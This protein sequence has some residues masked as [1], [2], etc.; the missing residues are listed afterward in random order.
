MTEAG[1]PGM[2][3][4]LMDPSA[5]HSMA[6]CRLASVLAAVTWAIV[7]LGKAR[8]EIRLAR[9]K[10]RRMANPLGQNL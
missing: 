8:A 5:L 6:A 3:T 1:A 4:K 9:T 7:A 10:K 2:P